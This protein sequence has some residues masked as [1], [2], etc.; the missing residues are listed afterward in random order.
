MATTVELP[1]ATGSGPADTPAS[2]APASEQDQLFTLIRDGNLF[3]VMAMFAGLGLLLSFTP[4]CLPM[5]PILSGIIVGHSTKDQAGQAVSGRAFLL[6]VAFV[7]GMAVTYTILGAVFA[8]AGSQVQAVMQQPAVIIGVSL[9]F[10]ALA[11]SMFGLFDLQIPGVLAD[12]AQHLSGQQRSG[13]FIGAGIMGVISAAV[14]TTCVTPPLVAALTVIAKTG[15]VTRGAM[16]L[17]ALAIGMGI[18]LLAIG[19]SAGR[20]MPK[21]GPWMVSVKAAFGLMMLAMAVWMLDRL[22]P[23]TLTLALWAILLVMGGIFLGA[24]APLDSSAGMSRKLGKGFGIV[25]ILYGAALLIGAL[26]GNEDALRPL[27]F[28]SATAVTGARGAAGPHLEFT[29]I[30][31]VGRSRTRCRSRRRRGPSGGARFLR[32]LVRVLQGN[33][34]VHLSGSG[35]TVRPDRRRRPAGRRHQSRRRRSGADAAVR[36]HRPPHHHVLHGGRHGADLAAHRRLQAGGRICCPPP[37]RVRHASSARRHCGRR[38]AA[39]RRPSRPAQRNASRSQAD[40]CP[41]GG[42]LPFRRRALWPRSWR[43]DPTVNNDCRLC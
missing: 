12:E 33:G 6:S 21:A 9:L 1:A 42:S 19:A 8:A 20:L 22:W 23:G 38:R 4:C 16:A 5:Y 27:Q 3:A 41:V 17:F 26:A 14:V 18:P 10:V 39:L 36:Y 29:R 40:H 35:R 28:S 13:S 34:E 31:T 11:L 15:D 25:A 30:K 32:G 24:F 7:L 2:A 37:V 43:S